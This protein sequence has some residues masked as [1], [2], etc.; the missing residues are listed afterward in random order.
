MVDCVVEMPLMLLARCRRLSITAAQ[1][2]YVHGGVHRTCS[3][4]NSP[5]RKI[6]AH[7][8]TTMQ[9]ARL[10]PS[11]EGCGLAGGT[12][13]RDV[14]ELAV[15][16]RSSGVFSAGVVEAVI[17]V[18]EELLALPPSRRCSRLVVI[19]PVPGFGVFQM[20]EASGREREG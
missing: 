11:G 12:S 3:S 6:S 7:M 17:V 19:S 18:E 16:D 8:L 13:S 4:T 14:A 2:M 9:A 20:G 15:S 10:K 5:C 1:G